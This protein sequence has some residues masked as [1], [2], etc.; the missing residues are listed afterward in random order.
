[1]DYG[2][3]KITQHAL[4]SVRAFVVLKM[5]TEEDVCSHHLRRNF[6][7]ATLGAKPAV[8]L[9]THSKSHTNC[10]FFF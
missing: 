10:F 1:M 7:E 2:N 8:T 4:K 9:E 3:T 6:K 5:D